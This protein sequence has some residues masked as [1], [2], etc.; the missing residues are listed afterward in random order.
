MEHRKNSPGQPFVLI[1]LD[2]WLKL[3]THDGK[4]VNNNLFIRLQD[5]VDAPTTAVC[6]FN[7]NIVAD[8]AEMEAVIK[9]Y[10]DEHP[11]HY[12]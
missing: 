5:D 7:V 4:L 9:R 12:E 6:K 2:G 1:D 11:G 10:K 8:R 3:F